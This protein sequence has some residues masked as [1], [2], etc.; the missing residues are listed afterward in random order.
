M[1][2]ADVYTIQ[3]EPVAS[4]DLMERAATACVKEIVKLVDKNKEIVFFCGLGNNG[5]DGM[6]IARLLA[7]QSFN[8]NVFVVKYSDKSSEDFKIN[9]KR[10]LNSGNVPIQYLIPGNP[11][12]IREDILPG[13]VIIDAIFGSGLN[14]SIEGFVA[15]VVHQMNLCRSLIIAID[16]ASGL[17]SEDNSINKK[18]NII[19][20]HFTF[21]FAAPKLAFMFPENADFVGDFVVLDIGLDKK[22]ISGISSPNYFILKEDI[23]K[24]VRPRK[25]N[26]HKG[27]YGHALLV[28][29]SY[30]KIGAAVLASEACLRAGVG[31]LTSHVPECGYS[32]LQTAVPEAM[33]NVDSSKHC[34]SDNI[35]LQHYNVIGIGPGLGQAKETQGILKLL[36]QNSNFPIVIDADAINIISENKT[37]IA[38]VPRSSVFTP[39]PKEFER[40]VGKSNHDYERHQMQRDFAMKNGVFVVLKL[41]HTAIACPDGRMFFNS[42]G[43]PGMATGGSGDV[44][45]GVL[46]ALLAQGYSSLEACLLGVYIHGLAGD[47]AATEL[48]EEALIAGDMAKYLGK[49]FKYIKTA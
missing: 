21:T 35:H 11:L 40:L 23:Q 12:T 44:L 27:T 7:E 26:A 2:Q 41:A 22:I 19:R 17:F 1:R 31:L 38:F 43:N 24:I 9:E 8:V 3:N 42:T 47:M 46:T 13:S 30:G 18:E 48:S 10:L 45:T 29:G 5:G 32:I 28:A 49:A 34:L 4:I 14:K 39:H 25:K 15:D 20:A 33:V 6:A 16:I 36:I 37:W